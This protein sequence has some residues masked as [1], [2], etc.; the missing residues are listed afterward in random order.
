M[1]ILV[2]SSSF[3]YP[4]DT[5]RKVVM[6]GFLSFFVSEFGPENILYATSDVEYDRSLASFR[7]EKLS[8]GNIVNR[9]VSVAWH[10]F[11]TRRRPIQESILYDNS[12]MRKVGELVREFR[13]DILFVDTVRMAQYAEPHSAR[14]IIYLD[15][16]YSMRYEQ[17]LS[18]MRDR[19]EIELNAL[20]SFSRFLPNP[21]INVV[22]LA[23]KQLLKTESK[24]LKK[25]EIN[26]AQNFDKA[27]LLN[28]TE[29][30]LLTST[31]MSGNVVAVKPLIV[32]NRT[33]GSRRFSG[34]PVFLFL[35]NLAVPSNRDS[36]DPFLNVMPQI[37]KR[38][39][40]LKLLVV[41][42]GADMNLRAKADSQGPHI[43]F[44]DFVPDLE[45]LMATTAALI[46]PIVYGTG[47]KTKI[48]DALYYGLPII[49]TQSGVDGTGIKAGR[50]AL[51]ENDLERYGDCMIAILD[52]QTNE[53]MSTAGRVFYDARYA[54]EQVR[55]EYREIFGRT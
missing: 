23:Q 40:N 16:L 24:L 13:P 8:L 38:I 18:L 55:Q 11:V 4:T 49:S 31:A 5:G 45:P 3:P 25:R 29:A 34:E 27:L 28:A 41:G 17:M 30:D 21:L 44:L 39:P 1:K 52:R 48:L 6:A 47:V 35:G 15:D 12:A 2:L 43:Q 42:K 22:K 37:S 46:A 26:V 50:E 51:V 32:P 9:G 54:P 20:G 14:K 53:T 36:L 33:R 7:V 10:S 19:P